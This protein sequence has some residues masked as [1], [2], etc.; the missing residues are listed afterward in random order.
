ME[1]T[2]VATNPTPY[3]KILVVAVMLGVLIG[4]TSPGS[5]GER[6]GY[7]IGGMV[8]FI[9]IA[10]L[11][12]Y[13]SNLQFRVKEQ[14]LQVY[15]RG[16]AGFI[17]LLFIGVIIGF[18]APGNAGEKTGYAFLGMFGAVMVGVLF[19]AYQRMDKFTMAWSSAALAIPTILG[20]II[21]YTTKGKDDK[22]KA[23]D[24][25][26]SSPRKI[27]GY[28]LSG[29]AAV[30][31]F[32]F[33]YKYYPTIQNTVVVVDL[34]NLD[35][36]FWKSVALFTV[37]IV[38]ISI[39]LNT[40]NPTASDSVQFSL[41]LA[42]AFAFILLGFKFYKPEWFGRIFV[43]LLVLYITTLTLQASPVGVNRT[44]LLFTMLVPAC[45]M[46]AAIVNVRRLSSWTNMPTN[47]VGMGCIFFYILLVVLFFILMPGGTIQNI[48]K[49]GT[50]VQIIFALF[51]FSVLAVFINR[52]IL[53]SSW[54]M[55]AGRLTIIAVS[56]ILMTY[57]FQY[58]INSLMEP[59]DERST[60]ENVLLWL[61]IAGF[62]IVFLS[63]VMPWL[64]KSPR[65]GS[66]A[67]Q[68]FAVYLYCRISDIFNSI[69]TSGW[70]KWILVA[71]ILLIIYYAN[72][73]KLYRKLEEGDAG[74]QLFN[75]PRKLNKPHSFDVLQKKLDKHKVDKNFNYALSFWLFL[76]PQ[77]KDQDPSATKYVRLLEL[78]GMPSVMYH[79]GS[80]T[81][82]ITMRREPKK[83]IPESSLPT[84][85]KNKGKLPQLYDNPY[86]AEFVADITQVPLQRWHHI[87][88]VYNSGTFDVYLNGVLYK[89]S[90]VVISQAEVSPRFPVNIG[91][92]DGNGRN[93]ICNLVA[94]R[95]TVDERDQFNMVRPPIDVDKIL[96]IYNRYVDKNPP[97][98]S[99][100]LSIQPTP[101]YAN[102]RAF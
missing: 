64:P 69:W 18:S 94:F 1:V 67:M 5:A 79:A 86:T 85:G 60:T 32:A 65:V 39:G 55:F 31:V 17:A 92:E 25:T 48:G 98:I 100:V 8:G 51:L 75:E 35:G 47:L 99:R 74:L 63:I 6:T 89:S 83:E 95:R 14:E 15:N 23:G 90:P 20:L 61:I 72:A 82:R 2:N 27:T 71:E 62:V 16:F 96:Q 87:V 76:T 68:Y 13:W 37:V 38:G 10:L 43:A 50:G 91:D 42:A 70:L 46:I 54:S 34:T 84:K 52:T 58:S 30:S 73:K 9:A 49:Q 7:A 53:L 3:G 66:A 102:I 77:P 59:A 45:L 36:E 41:G 11:L 21:G 33:L 101:S 4:L 44:E 57:A 78:N 19:M 26:T 56:L 40:G 81:I 12:L 22:K 28:V 93:M 29:V 24:P 97:I 88:L 80:N